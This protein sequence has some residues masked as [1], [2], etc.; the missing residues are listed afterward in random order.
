MNRKKKI[1]MVL[2]ISV[3]VGA[4]ATIL[5]G[6]LIMYDAK[7]SLSDIAISAWVSGAVLLLITVTATLSRKYMAVSFPVWLVAPIVLLAACGLYLTA[8][9]HRE[10]GYIVILPV[11]TLVSGVV[12]VVSS[13]I[14]GKKVEAQDQ[15]GSRDSVSLVIPVVTSVFLVLGLPAVLAGY[16]RFQLP[17]K[18]MF[19]SDAIEVE[20]DLPEKSTYYSVK[21]RNPG[22]PGLYV[23]YGTGK[24]GDYDYNYEV[25][26]I[27]YLLSSDMGDFSNSESFV[28]RA[29]FVYPLDDGSRILEGP[30]GWNYLFLPYEI[31]KSGEVQGGF[32]NYRPESLQNILL[33]NKNTQ[34]AV[35]I[36]AILK[37]NEKFTGQKRAILSQPRRVIPL[38]YE[39]TPIESRE[40]YLKSQ[41]VAMLSGK[42]RSVAPGPAV[43]QDPLSAEPGQAAPVPGRSRNAGQESIKQFKQEVAPVQRTDP[44]EE[45]WSDL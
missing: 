41:W 6:V 14:Q 36:F 29:R 37:D 42:E 35:E 8:I 4:I 21:H 44:D 9:Q 10:L 45:A 20:Y 18:V 30:D 22:L 15:D 3:L 27:A 28:R 40:R 32:D 34:F 43:R 11:A 7:H 12:I 2:Y 23:K 38:T 25:K 24:V 13:L 16:M 31:I 1:A 5:A 33:K 17:P 26:T 19:F 39:E